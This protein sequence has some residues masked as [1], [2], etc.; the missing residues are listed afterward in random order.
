MSILIVGEYQSQSE[1][2][3]PFTSGLWRVFSAHCRAVG[4]P[5]FQSTR[6]NVL[7][8]KGYMLESFC[9]NVRAEG[10][11]GLPGVK[12]GQKLHYIRS[13]FE[14]H[15]AALYATI[16]A[17]KPNVIVAVGTLA[18]W[19]LT[20]QGSMKFARGRLT[21]SVP[22][23]GGRKVIPVYAP[24]E[25]VAD[26]ALV[27][28][29]RADL[30]KA[31]RESTSPEYR[32][33]QRFLHLRPNLEDLEDFYHQYILPN[34]HLS[35]DIESLGGTITCVGFAPTR[36][37]A[38]VVP[39]YDQEQ[40]DGNYWASAKEEALAWKFVE[41]MCA[42]PTARIVGQNFSYDAQYF[43]RKMGIPVPSWTD[44]TMILHHALQPEMEKGLG[45]LASIYTDEGQWKRMV[46]HRSADR[47]GKKED[48]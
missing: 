4:L 24:R 31:V 27:P 23:A 9:T 37:R 12:L 6:T 21:R 46:K 26:P 34:S 40:K 8:T 13:E 3:G 16:E 30:D 42:L 10:V 18:L 43:L 7:Q 45:F 36:D 20:G 38:L 39:F 44:D 35:V 47:T 41:R 17:E 33:P 1:N 15:I 25:V 48:L 19:V 22:Q 2:D 29:L 14:P 32:R 5:Y 11:P 28:I